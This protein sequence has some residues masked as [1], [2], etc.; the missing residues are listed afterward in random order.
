MYCY[1]GIVKNHLIGFCFET[2][3]LALKYLWKITTPT[4]QAK[5]G[6]RIFL[7]RSTM[8]I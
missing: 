2:N 3:I 5:N 8:A 1:S 4:L 7:E 6:F